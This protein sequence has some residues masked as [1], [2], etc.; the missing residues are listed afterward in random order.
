MT[1]RRSELAVH[2]PRWLCLALTALPVLAAVVVVWCCRP[3]SP[4]PVPLAD[5][6]QTQA[7][8][9]SLVVARVP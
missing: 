6:V 7:S 2:N 3:D 8:T 1:A 5:T 4:P 9:E